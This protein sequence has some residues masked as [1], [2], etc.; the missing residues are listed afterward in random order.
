M[1]RLLCAGGIV[2]DR[3]AEA[4]GVP[5]HTLSK[6]FRAEIRMG[7]TEIDAQAV[8]ALVRAMRGGGRQSVAAAK[9][10]TQARMRWTERIEVDDGKTPSDAPMRVIV[11]LVGDAAAPRDGQETARTGFRVPQDVELRG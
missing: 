2:L 4:I 6:H 5:R 10:W 7:A 11:E 1:V 3:I 9:W 8:G